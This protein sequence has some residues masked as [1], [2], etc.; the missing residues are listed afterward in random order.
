MFYIRIM[1][2]SYYT[3][4]SI[5]GTTKNILHFSLLLCAIDFLV[6]KKDGKERYDFWSR[7]ATSFSFSLPSLKKEGRESKNV[8]AKIVIK[9]HTLLFHRKKKIVRAITKKN[10]WKKEIKV[11]TGKDQTYFYHNR[12]ITIEKAIKKRRK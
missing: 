6:S 8:V 12:A 2:F 9:S 5:F 7:F 11:G 10:N 1:L 3:R 4:L